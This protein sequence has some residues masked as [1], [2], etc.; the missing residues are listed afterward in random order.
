[1]PKVFEEVLVEAT[2]GD[3]PVDLSADAGG[4][5]Q[6]RAVALPLDQRVLYSGDSVDLRGAKA[7]GV[8]TQEVGG[9]ACA[10]TR[11]TDRRWRRR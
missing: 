8:K 3:G 1:M 4:H 9:P 11:Q 10:R 2:Q 7:C 5:L 6:Q